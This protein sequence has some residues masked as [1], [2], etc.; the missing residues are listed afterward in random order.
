MNVKE[1]ATNPR[2]LCRSSKEGAWW[3]TELVRGEIRANMMRSAHRSRLA[4][5]ALFVYRTSPRRRHGLVAPDYLNVVPPGSLT[6]QAA[7][8]DATS[9][10]GHCDPHST[11]YPRYP[12][13]PRPVR[14]I[15]GIGPLNQQY[16]VGFD[17][18]VACD[19]VGHMKGI[20]V[21]SARSVKISHQSES[22][23]KKVCSGWCLNMRE[24]RSK[25]PCLTS[26][27]LG[28]RDLPRR[29]DLP[30]A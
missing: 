2:G 14:S 5:V 7:A 12:R 11:H 6:P 21:A 16:R 30:G 9:R 19:P 18:R 20:D 23:H 15:N 4:E 10:S 29:D 27:S 28:Y 26:G 3:P 13:Y 25:R 1:S 22:T 24:P 8:L 17:G